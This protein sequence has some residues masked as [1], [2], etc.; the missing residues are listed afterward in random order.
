DA[1]RVLARRD[2]QNE[3]VAQAG[4]AGADPVC[5]VEGEALERLT[6]K[7]L[8]GHNQELMAR[9]DV[10]P[11]KLLGQFPLERCAEQVGLVSDPGRLWRVELNPNRGSPR[12]RLAAP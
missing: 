10:E 4:V 2:Q 11:R 9:L 12:K 3:S 6:L 8:H 7:R 5:Q 1:S